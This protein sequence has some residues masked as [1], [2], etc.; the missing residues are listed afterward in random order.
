MASNEEIE[1]RITGDFEYLHEHPELSYQEKNTTRKIR[2]ELEAAGVTVLPLNLET[3][4]VAE[5]GKGDKAVAIRCDIDALPVQEETGLPYQ[6][7][8][9]GVM[10]ACGHD[11]HTA[12][13]L[14][15]AMLLKQHESELKGRV[16]CVFQP[17]EEAPGGARKILASGALDGVS[18][19]FGLHTIPMYKPGTFGIREGATHAAVDRFKLIFTGKGT[20]AAHPNLGIDTLQVA[21]H[22]AI[23]AQSIVSR[24]SDPFATN[25][26][27]ITRLEAGNT[28]NVIPETAILE[29]TVR[30]MTPDNR[31]MVKTRLKELAEGIAAS[32]GAKA[33]ITWDPGLP[34]MAN[35]KKLSDFA[36]ELAKADGFKVERTPSSLGGEDFALYE[37]KIPGAFVH[38]GTG[39]SLP[40]HNPRFVADE[41]ALFPA[42]RFM[43]HLAAEYLKRF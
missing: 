31:T 20:H 3:G 26:V 42:A 35:D 21:A 29:G 9:K 18:A 41:K 17:A 1:K 11:F 30:T 27:S 40:N 8:I 24:N 36:T 6:S 43:A 32:F 5:I 2:S 13:I 39:P 12:A 38:V 19:I 7:Q 15:A 22:F 10:H 16:R 28:W 33:E 25:L 4:A 14:G 34:P 37:E 23:A